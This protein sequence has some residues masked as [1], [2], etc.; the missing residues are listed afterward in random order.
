M[1][2]HL[3]TDAFASTPILFDS[4]TKRLGDDFPALGIT[5]MSPHEIDP[6]AFWM[7]L[8]WENPLGLRTVR[9]GVIQL[10]GGSHCE[11]DMSTGCIRT[12]RREFFHEPATSL[13]ESDLLTALD[14]RLQAIA[15]A[16]WEQVPAGGDILLP[17]SGGL[18]SRL[19]ACHLAT[20]GD[21][22]RIRAVT[23]GYGPGSYEYRLARRI[24]RDLKIE[25][26]EFHPL[27]RRIYA[28]VSEDFYRRYLGGLSVM[29]AHL[30]TYLR[31]H[32]PHNA[33]LV[34]GF[35][36]DAISGWASMDPARMPSTLEGA[37]AFKGLAGVRDRYAMPGPI[38]DQIRSDL[39]MLWREWAPNH[40]DVNFDEY[41]YL[42]QRQTKAYMLLLN[43]Y[44]DFCPV[45]M[46]FG[47][48]E[49]RR[50]LLSAP[51]RLRWRKRVSQLLLPERLV[52]C[53]AQAE[54]APPR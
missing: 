35:G 37:K 32:P 42:S 8:V 12:T 14:S 18:D 36:A 10:P 17:L 43:M 31:S 24:C 13:S 26:H 50:L 40:G 23:F 1:I 34:S 6:V 15:R 3:D 52:F 44:R 2:K 54:T 29:H 19:L 48:D 5:A 30:Y 7:S 51:F 4:E 21:P 9:T 22:G 45:A 53:V 47:D 49:L 46:P 25:R 41:L 27:S 20:T 28:E 39:E 33:L 16:V 38:F 11:V